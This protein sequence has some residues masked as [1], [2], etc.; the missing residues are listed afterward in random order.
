MTHARQLLQDAIYLYKVGFQEHLQLLNI[1]F[2]ATKDFST[3]L[4]LGFF[5][6]I[7]VVLL[8][9]KVEPFRRKQ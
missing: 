5:T 8:E 1:G 2:K 9:R 6:P 4:R 3:T 7:D